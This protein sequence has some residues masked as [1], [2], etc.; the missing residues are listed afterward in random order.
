MNDDILLLEQPTSSVD[1]KIK[2]EVFD[3]G[4]DTS[5]KK[6]GK[7]NPD[8][9]QPPFVMILSAPRGSG[10]STLTHTLLTSKEYYKGV[11]DY[12]IFLS[13]T[14]NL[15]DDYSDIK[16]DHDKVYKF[17][18]ITDFNAIINELIDTQTSMVK[19]VKKKKTPQVLI[20]ADDIIDS[21]LLRRSDK[22]PIATIAH[23][24]RH[25]NISIIYCVQKLSS[26]PR[27]VRL[28][29]DGLIL[30]A[31]S[32]Y[33]ELEQFLEQYVPKRKRCKLRDKLMDVYEEPFNFIFVN[34]QI[35]SLSKRLRIKFSDILELNNC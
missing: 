5:K 4:L 14:L 13:P 3:Y 33:S 6:K 12:I 2:R 9:L 32:N 28:N 23:R 21:D 20:I 24:G 10:K 8:L 17:D 19:S 31:T 29:A 1:N 18:K 25:I 11:F 30:F 35:R 22:A 15:N 7:I 34:N 26:I 27:L 16:E